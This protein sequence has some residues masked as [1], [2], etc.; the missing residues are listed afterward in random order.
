MSHPTRLRRHFL[1]GE[2][3]EVPFEN[4]NGGRT[5]YH[6]ETVSENSR[7]K[8][9]SAIRSNKPHF[10]ES[11]AIH[12]DQVESFNKQCEQGVH[13]DPGTGKMVSTSGPA[14]EREARRRG[15]SF[16]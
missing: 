16:N 3:E 5:V 12:V 9:L 7:M 8:G 2:L 1:T 6:Y 14:R 10:S 13:Y 15:L 4:P 11:G